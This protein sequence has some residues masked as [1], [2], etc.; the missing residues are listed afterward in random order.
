MVWVCRN[1]GGVFSGPK[2]ERSFGVVLD[3]QG[4]PLCHVSSFALNPKP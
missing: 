1:L 3:L 2:Q 4:R